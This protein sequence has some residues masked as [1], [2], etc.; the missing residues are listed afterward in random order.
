ME[1]NKRVSRLLAW[2][3]AAVLLFAQVQASAHFHEEDERTGIAAECAICIVG[4]QI[5]DAMSTDV[6]PCL[7]L[8]TWASLT[9]KLE[10]QLTQ[11]NAADATARAP[12]VS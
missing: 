10:R 12:P 4:S 11:S 8:P 9:P 1:N 3:L 2:C 7:V 5:D 6:D